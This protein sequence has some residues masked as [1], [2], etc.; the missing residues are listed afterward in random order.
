MLQGVL[1]VTSPLH[2]SII[3]NGIQ[4]KTTLV[5]YFFFFFII[6][7]HFRIVTASSCI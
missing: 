7:L 5:G 2:Q 4:N 3:K 6:K 1:N